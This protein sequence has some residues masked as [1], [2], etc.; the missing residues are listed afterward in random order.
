MN[1][2]EEREFKGQFIN[3]SVCQERFSRTSCYKWKLR[4]TTESHGRDPGYNSYKQKRKWIF[5]LFHFWHSYHESEMY[6][7]AK[8]Q[9]SHP[10]EEC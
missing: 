2:Q 6:K 9:G 5:C 7:T 1:N 8:L 10:I 4:K 3:Y